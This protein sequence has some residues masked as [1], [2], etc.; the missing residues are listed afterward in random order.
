[1]L[2]I[3]IGNAYRSDDGAGL[4]V[5]RK[6]KEKNLT[7]V[8]IMEATGEGTAL[9]DVWKRADRV[10]LADAVD[11][12]EKPGTIH[13]LDLQKDKIPAKFFHYS[14]HAFSVAEAVELARSLNQLPRR[15]LIYGIEG[16]NFT[17]GTELSKE[18]ER[19]VATV[20]EEI[21]K[22]VMADA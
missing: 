20:A 12:G 11:S 7:G 19:A 6:L 3:G 22:E 14:T 2:I 17:S 16:A 9:I 15:F 1:M 21:A 18:V 13:R 10:I 4:A 5:T 8:E